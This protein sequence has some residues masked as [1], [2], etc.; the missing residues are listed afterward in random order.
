MKNSLPEALKECK[1]RKINVTYETTDH[2]RTN[3]E[4]MQQKN[5]ITTLE[6][7]VEKQLGGVEGWMGLKPD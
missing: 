5:H 1:T 2:R 4:E 7:P 3:K 6:P